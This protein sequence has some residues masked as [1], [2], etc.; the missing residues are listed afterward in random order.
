MLPFRGIPEATPAALQ[1][2]PFTTFDQG[3]AVLKVPVGS[4]TAIR[5]SLSAKI[6]E[7]DKLLAKLKALD[8]PMKKILLLRSCLGA[9]RINHLLRVLDFDDG[10]VLAAGAAKLIRGTFEDVMGGS[11]EA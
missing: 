8:C 3:A 2:I 1:G 6:E 4:S 9:C 5:R 10:K 7:L 11:C